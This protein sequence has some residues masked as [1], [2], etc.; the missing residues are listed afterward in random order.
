MRARIIRSRGVVTRASAGVALSVAGFS[1]LHCC[2][3]IDSGR[4]PDVGFMLWPKQ[5]RRHSGNGFREFQTS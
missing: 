4:V 3:A 1:K 2:S 5:D